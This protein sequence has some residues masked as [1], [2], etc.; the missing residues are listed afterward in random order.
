MKN[1]GIIIF[2][3]VLAVVIIAVIAGDYLSG[4]PDKSAPNPF[5]YDVNDFKNVP[6]ELI[7]YNESKNF[8]LGFEQATAITID[9]DK[10]FVT[11]DKKLQIIDLSGKLLSEI[12]LQDKSKTVE[13]YN[14]KIYLSVN[15]QIFVYDQ[16]G[17]QLNEWGSPGENS[18]ITAISVYENNVFV[19][20]AGRRKV[21]RYSLQGEKL[22]EFDGK[23]DEG[24]VHGFIIPSPYFDLDINSDGDLWVVN[25]GLHAL[26]NYTED[27]NLREHWNNTTMQ[28]EG[29]SGCCNPAHF[30]FLPDGRFVTSEKGLVRIKTYKPSGEFEG[31]VAA[32]SKFKDEGEAPDIATDS[33]GNIYALDYDRKM[34]RVFEPK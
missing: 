25:P 1:K 19:A 6:E 27:G 5:A 26:E 2:L 9:S 20:D 30:T 11:G 4:R 10:L 29:F 24:V 31:V 3:I 8:K 15:N 33:E 7:H 18:L 22:A 13:V 23:A 32:P 21:I 34:I 17:S 14:D 28:T 12:N 16:N